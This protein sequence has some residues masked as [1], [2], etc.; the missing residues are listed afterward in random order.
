M[1][2][3]IICPFYRSNEVGNINETERYVIYNV[4]RDEFE[5]CRLNVDLTPKIVAVCNQ[6]LKPTYFTLTFR[7]FS[8]TP[9]A[10]EFHPGN[11]YFFMSTS[12]TRNLHQKSGGRCRTHNMRLVFRIRDVDL[13]DDFQSVDH[14]SSQQTS[15]FNVAQPRSSHVDDDD[16]DDDVDDVYNEDDDYSDEDVDD[17][18]KAS[19]ANT[20]P[21]KAYPVRST[22]SRTTIRSDFFLTLVIVSLIKTFL[23]R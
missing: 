5:S 9:G 18:S 16:V 8:P 21:E 3:N 20:K 19:G 6:P 22:S 14:P 10:F 1:K 17:Q 7:P 12:S 4:T 2:A 11:D 23:S 13:K 15:L